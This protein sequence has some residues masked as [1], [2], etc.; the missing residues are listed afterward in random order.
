MLHE[1]E[2]LLVVSSHTKNKIGNS[3]LQLRVTLTL[4]LYSLDEMCIFSFENRLILKS[5]QTVPPIRGFEC[6]KNIS[7]DIFS[8]SKGRNDFVL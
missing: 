6:G 3:F 5:Q 8:I 4:T 1:V 2:T 7:M